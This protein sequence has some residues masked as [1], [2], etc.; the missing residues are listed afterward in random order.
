MPD[1]YLASQGTVLGRAGRVHIS[2]DGGDVWV[3]GDAVTCIRGELT[4]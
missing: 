4:I 3:A 2:M 1:R